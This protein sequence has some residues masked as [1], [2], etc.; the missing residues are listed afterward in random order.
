MTYAVNLFL[1]KLHVLQ[2][3]GCCEFIS[4]KLHVLQ[5]FRC[6]EFICTVRFDILQI[7]LDAVNLFVKLDLII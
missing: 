1:K 7:F 3:F 5:I 2:I 6:C 4:Q